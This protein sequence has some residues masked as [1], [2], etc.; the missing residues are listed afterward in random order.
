MKLEEISKSRGAVNAHQD[1]I[2]H[3]GAEANRQAVR[4]CAGSVI[5][6]PGVEDE[7]TAFPKDVCGTSCKGKEKGSIRATILCTDCSSMLLRLQEK[8]FTYWTVFSY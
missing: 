4:A 7:A 1:A 3:S 8:T 2:L 6:W 5:C